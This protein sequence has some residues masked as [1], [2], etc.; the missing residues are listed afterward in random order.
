[1]IPI[2]KFVYTPT[3]KLENPVKRKEEKKAQ[4]K[5]KGEKELT[6]AV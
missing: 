1:L 4:N 2:S 5:I 6:R 3:P